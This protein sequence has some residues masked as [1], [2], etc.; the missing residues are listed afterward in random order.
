[1]D[2]PFDYVITICSNAN[3][4]CPVFPGKTKVIHRRFDDP[5][6]L[7]EQI[8]GEEEKMLCYRRVRDELKAFIIQLPDILEK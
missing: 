2:I 7:T 3:E 1:M 4:N 8:A 5:S 6:K